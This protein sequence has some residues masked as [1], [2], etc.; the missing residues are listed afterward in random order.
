MEI[1]QGTY[2]WIFLITPGITGL[3]YVLMLVPLG[4]ESSGAAPVDLNT[5]P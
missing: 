5:V 3:L 2:D 1:V 4:G